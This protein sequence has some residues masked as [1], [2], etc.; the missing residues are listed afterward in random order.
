MDD[1]QIN[2]LTMYRNLLGLM[3][4]PANKTKFDELGSI[5]PRRVALAAVGMS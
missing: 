4:T 5:E 1:R 2:R 3:A